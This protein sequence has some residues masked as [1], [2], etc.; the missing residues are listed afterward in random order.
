VSE[1]TKVKLRLPSVLIAVA[2]GLALAD[3]SVVALALPPI[4]VAL[5]TGVPGLAAVIG[6]YVAVLAAGLYPAAAVSRRIG[7][8]RTGTVGFAILGL[9][10][11]GCAAANSIEVL[12]FFRG[13]Q[14][15]GG[16]AGVLAA[17]DLLDAGD[18]AGRQERHL[19]I[20]AAV[21][22]TA[23]GPALG[24]LLTEF[25]S[26]RLIF[27]AQLPI[28]LVGA[29]AC[30]T[31]SIP[32]PT[33]HSSPFRW[34]PL[35]ALAALAGGLTAVLFTLVLQLVAGWS[36]DPIVAA[37]VVSVL[38][39]AAIATSWW[40][41]IDAG[42]RAALGCLMVGVGTLCL[43][44]NF[45][46]SVLWTI[47]AQLIAGVGMGLALPALTGELLP[48]KST[49][50]AARLLTA[51][52]VGIVVALVAIAWLVNNSLGPSVTKAEEQAVAA[53]LD[54]NVAPLTKLT[55]LGSLAGKADSTSPRGEIHGVL[56]A[57]QQK[58]NGSDRAAFTKFTNQADDT[59]VRALNGAFRW[60]YL[61]AGLMALLGALLLADGETLGAAT[62][63]VVPA[64]AAAAA[65]LAVYGV[66]FF[67]FRPQAVK[68]ADPCKPRALP[69][70]GG[71]FGGLQTSILRGLDRAACSDGATR[72]ELVLALDPNSPAA[73]DYAAKHGHEPISLKTLT[74]GLLGSVPGS[75]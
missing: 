39:V 45:G 2:A 30:L 49:A 71:L 33:H 35:I 73:A 16:A 9:A 47:P 17:F 50:D 27:A 43:G 66:V 23:A 42:P 65:V 28:G 26:W 11:V 22:G 3:S 6:V 51:R 13:L 68:L 7:A 4:R 46:A 10:S 8:A 32:L 55:T 12:L 25:W 63:K 21:F 69:Q 52:H 29:G 5:H 56:V 54:S 53:L 14:A 62:R 72:E 67:A 61:V 74:G 31:T 37:L 20:A 44:I 60:A 57:K 75:G 38:P 19:W 24:G 34:K 59:I 64:I 48:E 58:L 1:P 70:A 36:V 41:R 15:I 40:T 18:Q